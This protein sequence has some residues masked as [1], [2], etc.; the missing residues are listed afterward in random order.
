M[1][2]RGSAG[3]SGGGGNAKTSNVF[4]NLSGEQYVREGSTDENNWLGAID[5]ELYHTRDRVSVK[6]LNKQ[7][8][9]TLGNEY[10]PSYEYG[11]YKYVGADK[12]KYGETQHQFVSTVNSSDNVYLSPSKVRKS[13]R[14]GGKL[15][16]KS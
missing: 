2:G 1:G 16:P 5:N 3:K 15:R 11:T 10:S 14:K 7:D 8:T 12:N 9:Y 13:V 4:D 6:E